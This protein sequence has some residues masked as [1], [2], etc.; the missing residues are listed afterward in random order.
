MRSVQ[1]DGLEQSECIH[2]TIPQVKKWGTANTP[3]VPLFSP[4]RHSILTILMFNSID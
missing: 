1:V 2:L 3:D 4:G